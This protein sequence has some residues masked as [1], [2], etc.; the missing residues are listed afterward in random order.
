MVFGLEKHWGFLEPEPN[1]EVLCNLWLSP[2]L[3][4]IS[5]LLALESKYNLFYSKEGHHSS[6]EVLVEPI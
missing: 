1:A 5:Y 2:F 3:L 4:K 6:S